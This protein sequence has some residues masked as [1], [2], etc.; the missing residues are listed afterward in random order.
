M[1]DLDKIVIEQNQKILDNHIMMLDQGAKILEGQAVLVT[2]ITD[3]LK[4]MTH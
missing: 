1:N 4:R 3:L 2:L